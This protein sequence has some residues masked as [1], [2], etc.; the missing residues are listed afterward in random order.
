VQGRLFNGVALMVQQVLGF[1]T[2]EF[3][4][5]LVRHFGWVLA[6]IR[7]KSYEKIPTK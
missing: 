7:V 1:V 5:L 3:K 4:D 6:N 2:K